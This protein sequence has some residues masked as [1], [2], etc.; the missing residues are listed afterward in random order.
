MRQNHAKFPP[1]APATSSNNTNT[2]KPVFATTTST[3]QK[4]PLPSSSTLTN[5]NQQQQVKQQ[6]AEEDP[7]AYFQN[8][9]NQSFHDMQAVKQMIALQQAETDRRKEK[10]LENFAKKNTSM[11]IRTNENN[12]NDDGKKNN[13]NVVSSRG[14]AVSSSVGSKKSG[15]LLA[16]TLV[17]AEEVNYQSLKEKQLRLQREMHFSANY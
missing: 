13:S 4:P 1:P 6:E 10:Q 2:Q 9:E 15:S 8:L 17:D 3:K 11:K 14:S 12:N 5:K 16:S 7:D